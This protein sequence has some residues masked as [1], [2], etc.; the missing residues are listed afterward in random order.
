M[1]EKMDEAIEGRKAS[2]NRPDLPSLYFNNNLDTN[3]QS[4]NI[5]Q[6]W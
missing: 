2:K 3:R 1:I 4:Y 5:Y 6:N